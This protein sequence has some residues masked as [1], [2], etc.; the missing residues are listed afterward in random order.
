MEKDKTP[1]GNYVNLST[2][3]G[4]KKDGVIGYKTEE[5]EGKKIVNFVWCKVCARYKEALLSKLKGSAKTSALS[6]IDGTNF[7]TK[8]SVTRHLDAKNGVPQISG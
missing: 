7:V 2:F 3:L 5:V 8:H 4:W 6:F 1:K